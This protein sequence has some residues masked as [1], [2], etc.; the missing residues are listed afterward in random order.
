[1][2]HLFVHICLFL[3]MC[4]L[5]KYLQIDISSEQALLRLPDKN[6][7]YSVAI[8]TKTFF[9]FKQDCIAHLQG[10]SFILSLWHFAMLLYRT[11]RADSK[12]VLSSSQVIRFPQRNWLGISLSGHCPDGLCT[13]P[14]HLPLRSL[15]IHHL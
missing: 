15:L 4:M 5:F 1:M 7:I 2:G 8:F 3:C 11:I 12:G 9:Y 10:K 14:G 6:N 13:S